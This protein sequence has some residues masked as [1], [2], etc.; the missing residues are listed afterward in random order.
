VYRIW[1]EERPAQLAAA[2]AYYGMFSFVPLIF[3]AVTVADIFLEESIVNER[4][5]E[6]LEIIFGPEAVEFMHQMYTQIGQASAGS[7]WLASLIS[8]LAV[9]FMASGLFFQLKLALNKIWKAPPPEKA[10]PLVFIKTRGLLFAMVIGAG[11]LMVLITLVNL[12]I[13][14]LSSHLRFAGYIS[15]VSLAVQIGLFVASFALIYKLLPDVQ[16]AWR[17]VWIGA[18]TTTLL[19]LLGGVLIGIYFR[20]SNVG[21]AFQAAGAVAVILIGFYYL[22]QI[23]L[24]GAVLTRVFSSMYGSRRSNSTSS[25]V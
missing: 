20:I 24:L 18:V 5:F 12:V 21:S 1:V 17:D 4:V 16:L 3:V 23:F 2:L 7:S 22:A 13:S 11:L 15:L 14:W 6:R 10:G 9:I 8:L 25:V 19:F